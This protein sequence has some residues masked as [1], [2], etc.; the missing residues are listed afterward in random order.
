[1]KTTLPRKRPR[2]VHDNAITNQ[3]LL[4]SVAA[5]ETQ[6]D[7]M[8]QLLLHYKVEKGHCNVKIQD[9]AVDNRKYDELYAFVEQI[10]YYRKRLMDGKSTVAST[11]VVPPDNTKDGTITGFRIEW[12]SID[13]HKPSLHSD[14]EQFQSMLAEMKRVLIDRK[15]PLSKHPRLLDWVRSMRNESNALNDKKPT[16]MSP[17]RIAGW[18][19]AGL[20]WKSKA[21]SVRINGLWNG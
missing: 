6:W 15:E 16:T 20:L 10:R 9:D 1:M 18:I 5:L 7:G 19:K 11:V 4:S 8:T 2:V 3:D 12:S 17:E 21:E 14:E 13:V